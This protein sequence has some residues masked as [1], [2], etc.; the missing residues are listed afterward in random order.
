MQSHVYSRFLKA[1]LC[2]VAPKTTVAYLVVFEGR[3]AKSSEDFPVRM[4][5][6]NTLQHN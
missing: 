5:A 6:N 1:K 4:S 2:V 3:F